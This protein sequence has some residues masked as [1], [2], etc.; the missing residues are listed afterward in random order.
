MQLVRVIEVGVDVDDDGSWELDPGQIFH[1]GFSAGAMHGTMFLALEPSVSVAV[2]SSAG[3]MAP[4]H[5]RWSPVRRPALGVLLEAR[6][7][8]LLNAPGIT[9]I[10]G[11]A[12]GA[13]HFDENKPLRNLPAVV[14]SV[15][16]A[17]DVQQAFEIHEW[18]QQSGQSPIVGPR[19]F[20]AGRLPASPPR[21]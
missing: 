21:P 4:E 5:A 16:G 1:L 2:E 6:V 19:T 7:P 12:V 9:A 20:E 17:T 13:P 11:V 3:G 14:N 10:D 15:S 8:S 18:G